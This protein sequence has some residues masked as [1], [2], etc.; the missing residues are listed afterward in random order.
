MTILAPPRRDSV[1]K[2]DHARFWNKHVADV[3]S[4]E[5]RGPRLIHL[6]TLSPIHISITGYSNSESSEKVVRKP[7]CTTNQNAAQVFGHSTLYR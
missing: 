4:I 1:A 3:N 2:K 6:K 5:L 7:I